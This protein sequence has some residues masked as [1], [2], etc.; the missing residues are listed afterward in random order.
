[1]QSDGNT[2]SQFELIIIND[3]VWFNDQ[4]SAAR[5]EGEKRE[6]V[7]FVMC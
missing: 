7:L 1:M 5:H 3:E 6:A 4:D 2:V